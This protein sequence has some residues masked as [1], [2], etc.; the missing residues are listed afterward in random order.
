MEHFAIVTTRAADADQ[1]LK[2]L[3]ADTLKRT[4][5]MVPLQAFQRFAD[6]L[7]DLAHLTPAEPVDV[8]GAG[9][10][11]HLGDGPEI[12]LQQGESLSDI[13]YRRGFPAKDAER[14]QDHL[15][16][17]KAIFFVPNEDLD[18]TGL[19]M[20]LDRQPDADVVRPDAGASATH[21][22]RALRGG[23]RIRRDV[24]PVQ[25]VTGHPKA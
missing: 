21:G 19:T 2:Q 6:D 7:S 9:A 24:R 15:V 13:L 23:T 18:P 10:C 17:G 11:V 3:S 4:E 14:V 12:Q 8:P 16:R 5:I 1:V 20:A 25:F 22:F